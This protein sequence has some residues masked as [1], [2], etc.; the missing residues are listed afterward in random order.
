MTTSLKQKEHKNPSAPSCPKIK[1]P[2][3]SLVY[4]EPFIFHLS[5]SPLDEVPPKLIFFTMS[6][7]DWPITE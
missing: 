6:Q 3:P 7:F 4:A 2:D 5:Y 1:K